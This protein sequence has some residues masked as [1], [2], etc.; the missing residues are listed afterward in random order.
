MNKE[1]G[2]V[3]NGFK[4]IKSERID[5]INSVARL[6]SHVKSGARLLKLENDDDNKVF[7]ISFRTPPEDSTGLPHI[8]EHSVLCGSRK[9]PSKEPFVE[10]VKG[11]LNTFLNALTFSDKTMYPVASKNQKDFYNLMD[12]YLDAV[13]YPNIYKYPEILMQEGWHYEIDNKDSDI[14]YKGVVYNEMKGAFSAPESILFRKIQESL[15]P[16]TAY[17]RESGGDPEVIPQ[18]TLEQFLSF[19]KK[20]YHPAN[21]Y[22]YLYGSGNIDEELKFIDDKYLKDF[23]KADVDSEI[24]MQKSFENMRETV[25]EYP[26][27]SGEDEEDKT[28]FS[29]SIVTG[30]STDPE[31][32]MAMQIL[33]HML[34]ETPAAPLKKALFEAEL[35]KDVFGQFDNSILQPVF[36]IVVKN[37]NEDKKEKFTQV[38]F[39]TLNKLVSEGI[40]KKLI[41]ASIN[42][43]EFELR[44]AEGHGWPRGLV[45]GIKC[46]DSWLYGEDPALHLS[47]E[48]S[49]AKVKAG[50]TSDYFE[51]LIKK[52]LLSNNH[53]SLIMLKPKK[54]LAEDRAEKVKKSLADFKANLSPDETEELIAQ[55]KKLR[56]R[57]AEP[58]SP[59]A[60]ESIPLLELGDIDRNAE[61]LPLYEENRSDIKLLLHPMFTNKIAYVGI[62]FDSSTVDQELLQYI[63]LLS[64]VLG[65]ISTEQYSYSDL[66]NEVYINTGGIN[67]YV[68]ALTENRDC[69]K[70]YPKFVVKSKVLVDRLPRLFELLKEILE[71]S[72]FDDERRLKEIIQE[73]R[74]Q[75]EMRI[76]DRGHMVAAKRLYSYFSPAGYYTELLSGIAYYKF[77]KD[78]EKNFNSKSAEIKNNLQKVSE[79][80]FNRR[81][82]IMSL[83]CEQDDYMKSEESISTF[84]GCLNEGSR[85]EQNY[86]FRVSSQNEG[87]MT[88]GN[89]QYVAKGYNF[90]KSGYSYTGSLQVLRTIA[91]YDYLWNHVRV[92]GGAYGAFCKF[93]RSGN[94]YFV[95]YRDPAL[96]ETLN[97]YDETVEFL[98]NFNVDD[99]EMTKYIIGTISKVDIPLTPSMKGHAAAENYIRHIT[100]EDIQKERDEILNTKREDIRAFSNLISDIMKQDNFCVLGNE[101]KIKENEKLFNKLINIFE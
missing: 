8:L 72:K 15:F 101:D 29:L 35:G 60:L 18:L 95:S 16:D 79:L 3:Y 80:V 12:V 85:S 1:I 44:E 56:E 26:I 78:L 100:Y 70:Y 57:Q 22:I 43:M 38:V 2:N 91:G 69:E 40:D 66:S 5:E 39:D 88:P 96:K 99:R 49:L 82:L 46:M 89:V 10:L 58:D 97:I 25:I 61:K 84:I 21:S 68:D 50:L 42:L 98:K 51:K 17:G 37:S 74:S 20:Y 34:L 65:K 24:Q 63:G 90:I 55:T 81:G 23:D 41:E 54:G 47:Y 7:S 4:L 13:F 6:F 76:F 36:S 48:S 64:D 33:E 75:L 93:D 86:N 77:I 83:T 67:F 53:C 28:F 19:H 14:I 94:A 92:R 30:Q 87:L 11:S 71:G 59:E 52:Y 73:T 45:Y 27:S 62:Y 32:Y 9:F 31:I